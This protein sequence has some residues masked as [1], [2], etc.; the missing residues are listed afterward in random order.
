[1]RA[2]GRGKIVC[3]PG[4]TKYGKNGTKR[5][6]HATPEYKKNA[7]RGAKKRERQ[8]GRQRGEENEL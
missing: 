1:M 4:H 8:K 7:L 2:Y 6:R 3:C 5:S